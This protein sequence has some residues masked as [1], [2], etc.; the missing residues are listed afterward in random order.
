MQTIRKGSKGKAVRIWQVILGYTGTKIDGVFGS[1]TEGDT[2]IWQKA[3]GLDDDGVVGKKS[4]KAG[5]ESV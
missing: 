4:W 3:H 1:G 5:L 2:K